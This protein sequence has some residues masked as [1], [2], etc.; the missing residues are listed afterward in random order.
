[1][2]RQEPLLQNQERSDASSLDTVVAERK[3]KGLKFRRKSIFGR[4]SKKAQSIV[5]KLEELQRKYEF[6]NVV[7]KFVQY[8]DGSSTLNFQEFSSITRSLS[9]TLRYIDDEDMRE[10]FE[11]IDDDNSG[12][13]TIEEL[14]KN[15]AELI[16]YQANYHPCH[17]TPISAQTSKWLKFRCEVYEALTKEGSRIQNYLNFVT[18]LAVV[19]W[20]LEDRRTAYL[21]WD[22]E[23]PI[24]EVVFYTIIVS[25]L[26]EYVGKL[27]VVRY[28]LLWISSFKSIR[29]LII[30]VPMFIPKAGNETFFKNMFWAC[31]LM[32]VLRLTS[33][34]IFHE[35]LGVFTETL[36]LSSALIGML[37]A[38]FTVMLI[39]NSAITC[40]AENGTEGFE[41][42]LHTLY[43]G[44]VTMSTLGYGDFYPTTQLGQ[45]CTCITVI[46]G[47]VVTAFAINIIGECFNEALDRYLGRKNDNVSKS[48][49]K[50]LMVLDDAHEGDDLNM[51]G[52]VDKPR[53]KKSSAKKIEPI[54]LEEIPSEIETE[55]IKEVVQVMLQATMKLTSL[56][57]EDIKRRTGGTGEQT[58]K[59]FLEE[60]KILNI[61][62]E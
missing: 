42:R 55:T 52:L 46:T 51:D 38:A 32:M 12:H 18:V 53:Q 30:V 36:R 50:S 1:M 23:V 27:L 24:Y 19:L 5:G 13:L 58:L 6:H 41:T 35:Y 4:Q 22:A 62:L 40:A 15:Y 21:K 44:I 59:R 43:W 16:R 17:R 20:L 7:K 47:I 54:K 39:I 2:T 33:I 57:L 61:L 56:D 28:K 9:I 37:L 34:P 45:L 14:Q 8:D 10:L 49:I 26:L 3:L 25:F 48:L 60:L 29:D 31:Q 11:S